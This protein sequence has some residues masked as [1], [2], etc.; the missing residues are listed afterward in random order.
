MSSVKQEPHRDFLVTSIGAYDDSGVGTGGFVAMSDGA[1]VVVDRIDSTGLV[2]EEGVV[3]R[4]ARGLKSIVGYRRDGIRYVLKVPEARDVHDIA[5]SS[6]CFICVSTGTN[7]V[8]WIDP[9]GR[10]VRRWQ[11]EGERDAWHLNCLCEHDGRWHVAAFG[12]FPTHRGWTQGCHGKGFVLDLERNVEV[13]AG[14]NGPH[15]PRW[16]DGAWV[17]CDSHIGALVVQPEGEAARRVELGGFTRGLAWDAWFYYVGVSANRKA[18]VVQDYSEVAIVERGSLAVVDRLRIPF[19]E[20]YEVLAVPTEWAR[21]FAAEPSR[22]RADRADDRLA[23]LEAQVAI[24]GREIQTLRA[25]LEPLRPFEH[26][27]SKW[28]GLCRRLGFPKA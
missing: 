11:A 13:L 21:D 14:L 26:W 23:A 25:R 24:S 8:L 16:I 1:A 2:F 6:G 20:I 18:A 27:H 4:F 15:N 17:V 3:F 12:R 7:E 22:F 19:P 5:W 28:L 9:L 10:I